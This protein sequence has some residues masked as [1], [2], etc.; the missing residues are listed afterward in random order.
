MDL[1]LCKTIDR[2]LQSSSVRE[3]RVNL[4]FQYFDYYPLCLQNCLYAVYHTSD[5]IINIIIRHRSPG[6]TK[7]LISCLIALSTRPHFKKLEMMIINPLLHLRLNI[8]N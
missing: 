3:S 7:R 6:L 4:S 2:R 1:E 8:F 5:Q